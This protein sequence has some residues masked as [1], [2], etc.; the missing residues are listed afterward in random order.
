LKSSLAQ[1][2]G[3]YGHIEYG[4]NPTTDML[5]RYSRKSI[6]DSKQAG[7]GLISKETWAEKTFFKLG[8]RRL[9]QSV[10]ALNSSLAQS[11]GESRRCKLFKNCKKVGHAVR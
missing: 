4:C 9:A 5:E 1:S 10:E 2:A 8:S 7:F 3:E 6:K 11:T